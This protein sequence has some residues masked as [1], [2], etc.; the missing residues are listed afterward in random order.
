[1]NFLRPLVTASK[2]LNISMSGHD[3][4]ICGFDSHVPGANEHIR[5]RTNVITSS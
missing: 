5:R 2:G 3:T 4:H 1:M